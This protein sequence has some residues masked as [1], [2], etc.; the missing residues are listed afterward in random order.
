LNFPPSIGTLG[1][2]IGQGVGFALSGAIATTAAR[3]PT[4]ILVEAIGGTV[5]AALGLGVFRGEPPTPPSGIAEGAVDKGMGAAEFMR[6]IVRLLVSGS[7]RLWLS[8]GAKIM[9]FG[10]VLALWRVFV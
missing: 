7:A 9:S 3:L 8:I 2:I 10:W 5:V 1:G 4:L 6:S